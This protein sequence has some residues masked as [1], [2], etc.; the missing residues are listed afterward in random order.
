[1]LYVLDTSSFIVL[2]HYFPE[3]FPTFWRELDGLVVC[4]SV[5]SVREV[6]RELESQAA[7]PHLEAWIKDNASIFNVPTAAEAEVVAEIFKV[8]R[9]SDLVK[10][11]QLLRGLPVAD[12]FVI[13]HAKVHEGCVVTEESDRSDAVRIPAVCRHVGVKC[14]NLEA[15][16]A[17][18]NMR[19]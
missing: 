17:Q 9:F 7:K 5:V 4:G 19:Y 2:S 1:L 12:P 18:E 3:R 15:L 16:M 13:A 11:K 8:P 6:R 14:M 10:R